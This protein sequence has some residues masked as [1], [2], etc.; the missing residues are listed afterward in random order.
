LPARRGLGDGTQKIQKSISSNKEKKKIG[1]RTISFSPQIAFH[2][3][4]GR[5]E[6]SL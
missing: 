3:L 1:V 5:E 4:L 6:T 2:P